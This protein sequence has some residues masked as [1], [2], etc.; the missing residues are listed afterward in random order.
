MTEMQ[1]PHLPTLGVTAIIVVVAIL[2]YHFCVK[3]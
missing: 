3:K 1:K 2:A